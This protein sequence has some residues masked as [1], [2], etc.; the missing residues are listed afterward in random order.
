MTNSVLRRY[1]SGTP[2]KMM[3][4]HSWWQKTCGAGYYNYFDLVYIAHW[5]EN[6]CSTTQGNVISFTALYEGSYNTGISSVLSTILNCGCFGL[7]QWRRG[8]EEK[9]RGE[10]Y[11]THRCVIVA[12]NITRAIQT[13]D[14]VSERLP[15]LRR[16]LVGIGLV[17]VGA[18]GLEAWSKKPG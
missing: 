12:I 2:G 13:P 11:F 5:D 14:K 4:Q 6:C 3:K 7:H 10:D 17:F 16:N 8:W 9:G 1:S 15:F 18:K